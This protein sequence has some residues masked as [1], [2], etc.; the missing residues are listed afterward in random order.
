MKNWLEGLKGK[1][2]FN[3]PL[4][5]YTTFRLGACAKLLAEPKTPD[6]LIFLL[7]RAREKDIKPLV[8]GG[9]SNLLIK[10]KVPL[11]IRLSSQEFTRFSVDDE[12]AKAGAGLSIYALIRKA[13][14]NNLGG[15]EFL[16]GIPGTVGGAVMMNA[17]V[18]WPEKK[19]AG[20]F[21]EEL[22]VLDK[23]GNISILKKDSLRFGYRS[24][25]L[26]GLILTSVVFRLEKKPRARITE[27]I[28]DFWDYR[29]ERQDLRGFSAGCVFKNP[30]GDSAG[31]LIDS[32]GLKGAKIGDAVVSRK[33]ANFIINR[34]KA[35]PADVLRLMQIIQR[36]VYEKHGVKLEPEIKIV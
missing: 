34:G 11:A 10:N 4:A 35:K 12:M 3:E 36:K 20:D 26:E 7:S 21:I 29:N 32:C 16:S 30:D 13:L 17:G 2:S 6:D 24:S 9:G 5:K 23:N 25:N 1:V 33:H 19:E 14:E 31:R 18:S 27:E 28:K 8:I 22:E 15:L